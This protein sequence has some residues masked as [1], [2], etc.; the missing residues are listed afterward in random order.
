M[1]TSSDG[2]DDG[3]TRGQRKDLIVSSEGRPEDGRRP[4][5][6]HSGPQKRGRYRGNKKVLT[7]RFK[8]KETIGK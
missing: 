3:G 6:K 5:Q 4:S 7:V 1:V 8:D 2:D